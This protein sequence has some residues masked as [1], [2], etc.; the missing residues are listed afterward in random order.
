MPDRN[1][2]SLSDVPAADLIRSVKSICRQMDAA[3]KEMLAIK[4][5]TEKRIG[6]L[7]EKERELCERERRLKEAED[8]LISERLQGRAKDAETEKL[9]D[10]MKKLQKSNET[11]L[12]EKQK[13]LK[14]LLEH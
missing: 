14:R 7:I 1:H 9:K 4:L 11:L 6:S 12:L 13:L 8:D 3:S 2:N 10:E 5:E